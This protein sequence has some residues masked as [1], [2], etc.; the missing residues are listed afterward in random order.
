VVGLDHQKERCMMWGLALR[1]VA[2]GLLSLL[3]AFT[4]YAYTD[5]A[6]V[7]AVFG[8]CCPGG[9][10]LG[11]CKGPCSNGSVDVKECLDPCNWYHPKVGG[12]KTP[13][14]ADEI[15]PNSNG[16]CNKYFCTINTLRYFACA[17]GDPASG[18]SPCKWIADP[19]WYRRAVVYEEDCATTG[20]DSDTW[21]CKLTGTSTTPNNG[22]ITPCITGTC[23]G[24]VYK[25]TYEYTDRR[26]CHPC[27]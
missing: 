17:T 13:C 4:V 2:L 27:P 21:T 9:E 6:D 15:A 7:R 18:E 20:E 23:G 24:G 25:N 11:G 19:G 14:A 1:T 26:I 10:V 8:A 5:D 3:T 12:V 16:K 22:W